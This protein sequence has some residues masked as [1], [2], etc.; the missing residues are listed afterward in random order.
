M[1]PVRMT[2]AVAQVLRAFVADPTAGQYGY[3]L[4]KTTGFA[5]GKLY[6]ILARLEQAGILRKTVEPIDPS[7]E[8]RPARRTY[9]ITSDGLEFARHELAKLH[10]QLGAESSLW[11]RLGA[12]PAG[13]ET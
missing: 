12:R 11:P 3:G 8:A 1:E 5:S 4:M 7:V 2:L 13:A 9:H 10:A 6:P